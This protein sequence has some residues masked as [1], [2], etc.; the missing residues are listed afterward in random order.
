MSLDQASYKSIRT[1]NETA[2]LTD[3]LVI[4]DQ[5]VRIEDILRSIDT[6]HAETNHI[7]RELFEIIRYWSM[8]P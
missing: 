3:K 6:Q 7:L 1:A 5:L 4:S 8:K 2:I